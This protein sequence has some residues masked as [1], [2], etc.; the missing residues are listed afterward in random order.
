[1]GG[2]YINGKALPDFMRQRII[3][4]SNQGLKAAE[5]SRQLR[6]SHGCVS[7]LLRRYKLTGSIKAKSQG[8]SKPTVAIPSVVETIHRYKEENP[9]IFAWE[10]REK[11]LLDRVCNIDNVPSI[12]SINRIVRMESSRPNRRSSLEDTSISS[13]ESVSPTTE[14]KKSPTSF[15]IRDILGDTID[16]DEKC[17]A[18][19]VKRRLEDPTDDNRK[20]KISKTDQR[21]FANT[22]EECREDR[23]RLNDSKPI[24]YSQDHNIAA[25]HYLGLYSQPLMFPS[26]TYPYLPLT[27]AYN[28]G[29]GLPS[30][31]AVS[32]LPAWTPALSTHY[33]TLGLGESGKLTSTYQNDEQSDDMYIPYKS[34]NMVKKELFP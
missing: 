24:T 3:I 20:F 26:Y 22:R 10:I 16:N 11:L 4:L 17:R 15:S 25:N 19:S 33:L 13:P 32:A 7:K 21:T 9:T 18:E 30:S 14:T 2:T 23:Y 34:E 1:M 31:Y 28:Y 6:V 5:I 12:S 27:S 8:G 29:T